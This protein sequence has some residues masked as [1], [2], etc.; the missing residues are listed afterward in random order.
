M[1]CG[2]EFFWWGVGGHEQS[3]SCEKTTELQL[4]DLAVCIHVCIC[5]APW[6]ATAALLVC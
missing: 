5:L 6:H 1:Q 2:A 4:N 3:D